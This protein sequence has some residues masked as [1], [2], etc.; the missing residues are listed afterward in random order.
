MRVRLLL[1]FAVAIN[2][3]LAAAFAGTL[4][5]KHARRERAVALVAGALDRPDADAAMTELAEALEIADCP[6]EEAF[7]GAIRLAE[8]AYQRRALAASIAAA[9]RAVVL[10]PERAEGWVA[11]GLALAERGDREAGGRDFAEAVRVDPGSFLA[12][13]LLGNVDAARGDLARAV[14]DHTRALV[15][16]PDD[17]CTL[18]NRGIDWVRLERFH[19]ALADLDRVV[20]IAPSPQAY[21]VR[22]G[23]RE[24]AGKLEGALGDFDKAIEGE[25]GEA[26][27]WS[28]R[29]WCKVRLGDFEGAVADATKAIVLDSTYCYAWSNRARARAALKDAKGALA[30]ADVAVGLDRANAEAWGNRGLAH[31]VLGDEASSVEDLRQCLARS[32]GPPMRAWATALLRD[33]HPRR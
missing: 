11:R 1:G 21:G 32:P 26:R 28:N 7:K 8:L 13:A 23:A 18:S 24:R 9:D 22:G 27:L 10:R 12:W 17:P 6:E 25:P 5:W 30:D 31:L 4:A 29:S 16:R 20:V 15:L 19:E 33:L 3:A 14:A 2:L